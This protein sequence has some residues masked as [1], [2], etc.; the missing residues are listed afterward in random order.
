MTWTLI[1]QNKLHYASGD[2]AASC[3]NAIKKS[4]MVD[5]YTVKVAAFL[6]P[7]GLENDSLGVCT[8]LVILLGQ[9]INFISKQLQQR[10]PKGACLGEIYYR[11][12]TQDC[13]KRPCHPNPYWPTG[14]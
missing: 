5:F 7:T 8:Q 4:M 10:W 6:L 2:G 12:K 11:D 13:F 9:S 3:E 14:S 1:S